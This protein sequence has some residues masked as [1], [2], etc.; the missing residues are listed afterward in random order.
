MSIASSGAGTRYPNIKTPRLTSQ[1]GWAGPWLDV[2]SARTSK[3][4]H[5]DLGA[6]GKRFL[7]PGDEHFARTTN[8]QQD[9]T[10]AASPAGRNG[11]NA[12]PTQCC[13]IP[14]AMSLERDGLVGSED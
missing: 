8:A 10:R 14:H 7:G 4:D 5:Q 13:L 9:L 3:S 12:R 2:D 1:A 6:L 11:H